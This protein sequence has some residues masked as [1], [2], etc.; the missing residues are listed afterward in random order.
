M[1][2]L[3]SAPFPIILMEAWMRGENEKCHGSE[4]RPQAKLTL[5]PRVQ[6]WGLHLVEAA[7]S[8]QCVI[9]EYGPQR[10]L[11]SR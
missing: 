6:R 7:I 8:A 4:T 2:L 9:S 1:P 11:T 10:T 3:E 5:K